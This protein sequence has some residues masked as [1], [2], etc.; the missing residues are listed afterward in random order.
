MNL[1]GIQNESSNP[2]SLAYKAPITYLPGG[3][4]VEGVGVI[5]HPPTRGVRWPAA[6]TA[7]TT[8]LP[9][10]AQMQTGTS[11]AGPSDVAS[12][13]P[14]C[15]TVMAAGTSNSQPL[16][17]EESPPPVFR[18]N[19]DMSIAA[20]SSATAP[21]HKASHET[22]AAQM[23]SRIEL[24]P[25]SERRYCLILCRTNGPSIVLNRRF[26]H[27]E[28]RCGRVARSCRAAMSRPRPLAHQTEGPD[29]ESVTPSHPS[30]SRCC[31]SVGTV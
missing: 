26:S 19:A 8:S 4:C 1:L 9:S 30:V 28:A 12:R 20:T 22:N 21:R 18:R 3:N 31:R 27:A 24:A 7:F 29:R 13:I 6:T 17:Q 16:T 10:T 14:I 15:V 5:L 25:E 23:T 2:Q 11:F